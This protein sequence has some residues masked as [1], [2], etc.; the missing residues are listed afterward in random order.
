M[1]RILFSS[2]LLLMTLCAIKP[3]VNTITFNT[4]QI[5]P[6][7]IKEVIDSKVTY[8][9]DVVETYYARFRVLVE[10]ISDYWS[11]VYTSS[12][13]MVNDGL[14]REETFPFPTNLLSADKPLNVSYRIYNDD[15]NV[16]KY[17]LTYEIQLVNPKTMEISE[18]ENKQYIGVP[19]AL[20]IYDNQVV[21]YRDEY[22]FSLIPSSLLE[23]T[24]LSIDLRKIKFT[25]KGK[26]MLSGGLMY[27]TFTDWWNNFP[28]LEKE[29]QNTV[30]KLKLEF[31]YTSLTYNLALKDGY[32]VNPSTLEMSYRPM[33]GFVETNTFYLPVNKGDKVDGM[34]MYFYLNSMGYELNNFT[35]SASYYYGKT[36]I[37]SCSDS[38]YC[39]I[40]E[41]Y[42]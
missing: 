37:G 14:I 16:I 28:Y 26:S 15:S 9:F 3:A 7:A 42:D 30:L 25:Y 2:S 38:Q 18:L 8:E 39:V 5:G 20:R 36:L 33:P 17:Y 1:V 24:Y 12:R 27:L 10:G 22:N 32:Y 35:F 19:Y 41:L 40:G 11:I 31:D 34:M 6:Y 13:F 21:Y 4:P 29:R 23:E